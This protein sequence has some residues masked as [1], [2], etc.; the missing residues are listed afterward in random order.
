MFYALELAAFVVTGI[1]FLRW[2]HLVHGNLR[3]LGRDRV[4]CGSGMAVGVWFI[5]IV[6]LWRPKQVIDDVWHTSDAENQRS[7]GLVLLWW[8]ALLSSE[9]IS[10]FT[11]TMR[12][13]TLEDLQRQNRLE[14]AS[15]ALSVGAAV[16]AALI[17]R[18]VTARQAQHAALL[19]ADREVVFDQASRYRSG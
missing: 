3:E 10:R 6:N 18:A 17:V 5:P 16:A 11:A 14:V 1:V 8:L 2:L 19:N 13:D 7:S 9:L 4:R 15:L 12:L